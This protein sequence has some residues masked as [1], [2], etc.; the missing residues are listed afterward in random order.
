MK[1]EDIGATTLGPNDYNVQFGDGNNLF[2]M[3]LLPGNF[4]IDGAVK[5]SAYMPWVGW[6]D[7]KIPTYA[8]LIPKTNHWTLTPIGTDYVK[9]YYVDDALY[10][11]DEASWPY[12]T[13]VYPEGD[14]QAF[15]IEGNELHYN[16]S[17]TNGTA[18]IRLIFKTADGTVQYM[19]TNTAL[20]LSADQ[21]IASNGD[22]KATTCSGVISLQELVDSKQLYQNSDFPAAAIQDGKITFAGLEIFAIGGA[23]VVINELR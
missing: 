18:S 17:I 10:V 22:F 3:D 16:F 4:T 13:Y 14:E 12:M 21:Y 5:N 19:M 20:G 11:V 6:F 8:G 23:T 7:G 9:Y 2:S 15:E 1:L